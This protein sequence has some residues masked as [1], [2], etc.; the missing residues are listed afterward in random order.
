MVQES[1]LQDVGSGPVP[2][3]RSERFRSL[4]EALRR[5]LDDEIVRWLTAR[6][7]QITEESSEAGE[8]TDLL[9]RFVLRGGKRLRPAL[10]YYAYH[11]CGGESESEV[12]PAAMA[13][14]L[15]HTYLLVHDDI[16]DHAEVRRAG[17]SAHVSFRD[18][19]LSRRWPGEAEHFGRS[20]AILLGDLAYTYA[21]E[22][23]ATASANSDRA[24]I[25]MRGFSAMCRE[26][27]V[28]QYLEI[29]A[30]YRENLN[31]ETLLQILRMKSGRYS[32][33]QPI[34]LGA[35]LAGARP[36]QIEALR[37]YGL[38]MGEA[39]QLQDDL[40]GVFGEAERVGKPVGAD[41]A[42]GK[43]TL[44]MHFTLEK[45]SGGD[46]ELLT[47]ALGRREPSVE[48]IDRI[49][50]IMKETGA[51]QRVMTMVESRL[52][53]AG[54]AL[55]DLQLESEGHSFFSGLIDHL[56]GRER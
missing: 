39:F 5:R 32:V 1:G 45:I 38:A 4:L 54:D 16:M 19:H 48:E 3:P 25:F 24:E 11:G 15:L 17:P 44:L 34:R 43:L 9:T 20:S 6:E 28:G 8:L 14:E 53:S 2:E 33:E 31:E 21:M 30:P 18:L 56:R 35:L 13:V 40:L 47:S 49:R 46:R 10:L 29:T 27:I 52:G 12:L 37:S 26:V 55:R 41:I 23:A 36:E 7:T 51:Q 50:E 22:L 42:E